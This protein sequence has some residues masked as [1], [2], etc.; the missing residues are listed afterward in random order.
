MY[1]DTASSAGEL[2]PPAWAS[3]SHISAKPD[4]TEPSSA[5]RSDVANVL[6]RMRRSGGASSEVAGRRPASETAIRSPP[7]RR[8]ATGG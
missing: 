5:A 6:T 1:Q 7:R 2:N 3:S 8:S 4:S